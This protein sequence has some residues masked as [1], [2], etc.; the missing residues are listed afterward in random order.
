M[1]F[2][3]WALIYVPTNNVLYISTDKKVLDEILKNKGTT[4]FAVVK[5]DGYFR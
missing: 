2:A 1:S 4:G 3:F 5:C